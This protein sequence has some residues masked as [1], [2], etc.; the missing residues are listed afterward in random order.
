MAKTTGLVA[1]CFDKLSMR[2][3]ETP[4]FPHPEQAPEATCRRMRQFRHR[5][6]GVMG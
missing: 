6:K 4:G 1:A 3:R 5:L 2:G